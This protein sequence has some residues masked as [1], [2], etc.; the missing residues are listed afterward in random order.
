MVE[1]GTIEYYKEE[2]KQREQEKVIC[3]N[4]LENM[5]RKGV[6]DQLLFDVI[7]EKIANGNSMI[8]YYRQQIERKVE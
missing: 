8:K 2:I 4:A 1:M 7:V 5:F 6:E 3:I